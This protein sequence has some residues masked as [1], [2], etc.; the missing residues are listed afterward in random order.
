MIG[1]QSG[2]YLGRRLGD[3][4]KFHASIG[5]TRLITTTSGSSPAQSRGQPDHPQTN[6]RTARYRSGK[7]KPRRSVSA[8]LVAWQSSK[9]CYC[10]INTNGLIVP[11]NLTVYRGRTSSSRAVIGPD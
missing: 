6:D 11:K 1:V 10:Q 3:P 9:E 5:F 2:K 4:S 7:I 8:G